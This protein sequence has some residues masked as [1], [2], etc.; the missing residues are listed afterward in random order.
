MQ[1]YRNT[2]LL[3][4]L[5]NTAVFSQDLEDLSFGTD[6]SLDIA[7]WNI[8]WFPKN[9]LITVEYVMEIINQLDLD[10]LA[11]QELDDKDMFEFCVNTL[12]NALIA[13]LIW[14][15]CAVKPLEFSAREL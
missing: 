3:L 1:L 8:E 15:G 4:I 6:Y 12:L 2:I 13:K 5:F 10:I 14:S 7:T 11:I 9:G